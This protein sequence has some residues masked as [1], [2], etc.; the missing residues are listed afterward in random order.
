MFYFNSFIPKTF[1]LI[2][3][4]IAIKLI[5]ILMLLLT[6]MCFQFRFFFQK[7][8]RV[9]MNYTILVLFLI[10]MTVY[11]YIIIP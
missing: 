5:T 7:I 8:K 9:I 6:L 10:V 1:Y 4:V 3:N 11:M 2:E